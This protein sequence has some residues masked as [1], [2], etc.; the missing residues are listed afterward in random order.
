METTIN[1]IKLGK[2]VRFWTTK[3][4]GGYLWSDVMSGGI[5]LCDNGRFAGSTIE[6]QG[7]DQKKFEVFCRN[8][9]RTYV[10]LYHKI[11]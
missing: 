4:E 9:F 1:S 8:W 11:D 5:Q 7:M 10:R 6:I 2:K 3:T